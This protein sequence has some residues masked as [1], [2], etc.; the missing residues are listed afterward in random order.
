MNILFL[1]RSNPLDIN[2][3]SGTLYH[4]FNKLKEHHN[5]IPIGMGL[6]DQLYFFVEK[7]FSQKNTNF[8]FRYIKILNKILSERINKIDFDLIFF[9][10]LYFVPFLEVNKPLVRLSDV[11]FNVFKDYLEI[12]NIEQI[13]L[14]EEIEKKGL[15]KYNAII[16][17]SDWIKKSTI[18]YYNIKSDKIYV[19]EFGANIPNPKNYTIDIDMDICHLVFIGRN[20]EKKGGDKVLETYR[21]L[22]NDGFP[23][24]LTI[25]GSIPDIV[26]NDKNLIIIPFLDKSKKTDMEKFCQILSKSHFLILPTKFDAFGI[27]FCEASAYAVPSIAANVGGVSQAI[28]EGKNGYLLSEDAPAE[29]YVTK[30]KS[31]FTNKENYFNL[32]K[33]S[34]NEFETRLNWDNWSNNVNKIL[35]EVVEN[36]R[37][38]TL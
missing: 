11:T 10:D 29:D 5:V 23:C 36:Y 13:K 14:T 26:P 22:Q 4:I 35:E 28:R 24:T 20:W 12:R 6:L 33:S 15:E 32:R 17:C 34:R 2:A 31:I 30:I 9:G 1:T 38:L 16:Y 18:Q 27:V 3:W 25:I 19:V 21:K 37:D 8:E 7:N